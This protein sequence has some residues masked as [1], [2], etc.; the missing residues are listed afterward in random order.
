MDECKS[1]FSAFI[2]GVV[3]ITI[4]HPFDTIKTM[5]QSNTKKLYFSNLY[6]GLVFP[7]IQNSIINSITFGSNHFF[8]KYNNP[9]IS[10]TYC[11]IIS[12]IICTPLDE[13]KIKRQ[14][15]L[16]YNINL[17]SVFLSYRNS[18]IVAIRELPATFMYFFTYDYLKQNNYSI[19]FSG[20]FAGFNSAIITYPID[21]IK[22]RIQSDECKTILQA[23]KKGYLWRGFPICCVRTIIVNAANFSVYEY[24]ME[25]LK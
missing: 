17:K 8:K 16:P 11:G 12:T 1:F 22:T 25:I 3:H 6:R 2:S 19:I 5:Q 18:N 4:G 13:F 24:L 21:T 14:F 20:A 15:K 7:L 10:Y 9:Y 23:Y